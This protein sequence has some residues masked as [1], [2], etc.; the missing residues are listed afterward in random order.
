MVIQ[1]RSIKRPTLLG[2]TITLLCA[3]APL[4]FIS[5]SWSQNTQEI[6]EI[7]EL[8]DQVN[9]RFYFIERLTKTIQSIYRLHTVCKLEIPK[10]IIASLKKL[11]PFENPLVQKYFNDV[12]TTKSLQPLFVCWQQIITYKHIDDPLL[13][14]EFSQLIHTLIHKLVL[15]TKSPEIL[16][17]KQLPQDVEGPLI[18]THHVSFRFYL[19][20]RLTHVPKQ[21]NVHHNEILQNLPMDLIF[22]HPR[23]AE[24]YE[25]M[26]TSLS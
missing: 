19:L 14:T 16:H 6:I 3:I 13:S 2:Y 11:K 26:Q 20:K 7:S 23:T 22:I 21:F 5:Q 10:E 8:T 9:A 18:S 25:N 15:H 4:I 1:K 17:L 12:I 24:C